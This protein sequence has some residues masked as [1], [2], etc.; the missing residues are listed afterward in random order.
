LEALQAVVPDIKSLGASIV[1][2]SPQLDKY[3]RQVIEKNNLTF[4]V[5]CDKG[6]EVASLF[7]LTFTLHED[8]REVYRKFGI[9]LERFNGDDSWTLPM[10][11]RFVLDHKGIILSVD[12]NPDYTKRPEPR[13]IIQT[14][15]S[16]L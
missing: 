4:S 3:S 7:G 11:G 5:L 12:V 9:D 15:K 14:L 2:I 10:P 8:L 13:D 1:V 16:Q 6:N